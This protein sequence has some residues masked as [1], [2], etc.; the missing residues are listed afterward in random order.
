V[1]TNKRS[2]SKDEVFMLKARH[3]I[4][5]LQKIIKSLIEVKVD[6]AGNALL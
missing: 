3:P 2:L 6:E 1:V 4:L 5:K